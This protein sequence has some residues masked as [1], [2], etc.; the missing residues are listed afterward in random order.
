[1]ILTNAECKLLKSHQDINSQKSWRLVYRA[2]RDGDKTKDFHRKC[3]GLS[4]IVV[5]IKSKTYNHVFGGFSHHPFSSKNEW[6]HDPKKRNWLYL[7]R[8]DKHFD[9]TNN[10]FF[11]TIAVMHKKSPTR[12]IVWP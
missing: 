9:K 5:I 4:P 7:V 11:S 2:S 1:M 3:D 8:F 10:F 12:L 6:T